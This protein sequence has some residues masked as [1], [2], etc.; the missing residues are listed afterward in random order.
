MHRIKSLFALTNIFNS[1]E[2]KTQKDEM[3]Q[4][5]LNYDDTEDI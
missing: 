4:L 1:S 2:R 3:L 5:L